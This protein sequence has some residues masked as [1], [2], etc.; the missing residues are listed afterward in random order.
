MRRRL[1]TATLYLYLAATLGFALGTGT[2]LGPVRWITSALRHEAIGQWAED[3]IIRGAIL[4]LLV[5]TLGLALALLEAWREARRVG[6][7]SIPLTT[8]LLAAGAIGLWMTPALTGGGASPDLEG[9]ARFVFGPYPSRARL[10]ELKAHGFVGVVSLLHPAVAPFEPRLLAEERRAAAE[11][12]I[13]LIHAPM[14]PWVSENEASLARIRQVASRPTGRYYVHCYLGK[15]R[16]NVVRQL[17]VGLGASVDDAGA[18]QQARQIAD[19]PAFERGSIY[20]LGGGVHVA[21]YPTDEEWFGYL[22][23][24][25]VRSIVSLLDPESPADSALVRRERELAQRYR[26]RLEFHPIPVEP[27]DA[28]RALTAATRARSLPRPVVVHGYRT[29]SPVVEAFVQAYRTGRAPLPPSLFREPLSGGAIRSVRVNVV[30]G[31]EPT[32]A[33]VEGFLR[34]R[35]IR[36][37][38]RYGAGA[39]PTSGDGLQRASATTPDEL[40]STVATGGPWYVY[41]SADAVGA[42]A[43]PGGFGLAIPA[44]RQ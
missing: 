32:Q 21:P 7:W 26:V 34:P 16:V 27:Y 42:L 13:Q 19:V 2:L 1:L 8:G 40:R 17:L 44:P 41:G 5:I 37:L 31:P 12:G 38:V 3:W 11:V 6:R 25:S 23:N 15:D 22:L 39:A 4:V 33:E 36:G 18:Q 14:L 9:D 10:A 24:G 30:Y 29:A 43:E 35:G 28:A 20:H